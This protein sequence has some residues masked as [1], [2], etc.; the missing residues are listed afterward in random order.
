MKK[1][2]LLLMAIL[3][4]G[5]ALFANGLSLNSIG[6]RA[7]GMGGAFVGL[8]NDYSTIYWNPA[9]L[10]NLSGSFVGI[11]YS[12]VSPDAT[13]KFAAAGIDAKTKSNL[14]PSPGLMGYWQCLLSDKLTIGLGAY[15]PAGLGAEWDGNDLKNL[16]GGLPFNWK[17][18]IGV[19]NFSPAV[20]YSVS[21]NF[22]IGLA[23]NVF[24][25][26]FDM[27]RPAEVDPVNHV[28]MQYTENSTGLGY[29][30]TLGAHYKMNDML[31]L[32]AS[33][34]TKTTV[35]MSGT[36]K[37]QA[38]AAYNAAET[39]F[40]RDVAWPMWL[41]G[42]IAVKPIKNLTITLDAQYSQWSESEN[43]FDTKYKSPVWQGALEPTG[44]NKFILKWKDATQIRVGA[45]YD[46]NDMLT[47]RAGYYNDPAP[48]PD[49]TYNILFPSISNNVFTGGVSMHF[50]K[51]VVDASAEYLSGTERTVPAGV[52]AKAI[53][54]VHN[55]NITA[56]SIGLGYQF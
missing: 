48:A 14:Y 28:F 37:N 38:F 44:D 31:S 26:I 39:D 15:V 18:Q 25:G 4:S 53:P 16:S 50:D 6:P 5:S 49:E 43:I 34:R 7:L 42:G 33:F 47:L 45:A 9:G 3:F 51:W 29:G 10:R 24:Y 55:M 36:A 21:D 41:A 52:Y 19:I 22:S 32:G 40:D 46:V 56:F 35:K 8:A 30:V 12:G 11:Y 1:F 20:A 2:S 13:Y 23:V 27:D 17:A 54:G